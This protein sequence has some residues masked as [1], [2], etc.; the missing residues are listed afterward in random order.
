MPPIRRACCVPAARLIA[1]T[2]GKGR[3]IM[4]TSLTEEHLAWRRLGVGASDAARVMSGDWRSLWQEKR[5][6]A[7]DRKVFGDWD[8][9]LKASMEALQLDWYEHKTGLRIIRN[10]QQVSPT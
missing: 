8:W 7:Q 2:R 5:G 10:E 1:N 6:L 9:A 4:R 3:E